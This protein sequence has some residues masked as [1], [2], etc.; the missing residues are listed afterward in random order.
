MAVRKKQ[1]QVQYLVPLVD[2]SQEITG[3]SLGVGLVRSL[4]GEGGVALDWRGNEGV[5]PAVAA[6][7]VAYNRAER[8]AERRRELE[9]QADAEDADAVRGDVYANAYRAAWAQWE[10]DNPIYAGSNAGVPVGPRFMGSSLPT[11]AKR[12]A[13]AYA[14]RVARDALDKHDRKTGNES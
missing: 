13:A 8:E 6:R 9:R 5:T 3:S 1:E 14:S 7:I 11:S 10:A 4:A 12:Q 2:V